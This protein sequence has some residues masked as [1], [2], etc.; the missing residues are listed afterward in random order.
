VVVVFRLV[1]PAISPFHFLLETYLTMFDSLFANMVMCKNG[2]KNVKLFVG[3][4]IY[5][6]NCQKPSIS[7]HFD[8]PSSE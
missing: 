8:P 6:V 5:L 2:C 1:S 7:L 3:Q 4:Y